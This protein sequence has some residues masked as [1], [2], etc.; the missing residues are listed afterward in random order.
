MC[1]CLAKKAWNGTEHED[2]TFGKGGERQKRNNV[3]DQNCI[4]GLITRLLFSFVSVVLYICYIIIIVANIRI[5][6]SKGRNGGATPAK[7]WKNSIIVKGTALCDCPIGLP[8]Q[9]Y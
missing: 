8:V 7:R 3:S 1:L 4:Y 2:S 5:P 6:V 9:N